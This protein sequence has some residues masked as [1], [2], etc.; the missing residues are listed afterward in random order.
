[1][2]ALLCPV[3]C[4]HYYLDKTKKIRKDISTLFISCNTIGPIK[5]VHPNTISGWIKRVI[6]DAYE[7]DKKSNG[8]LLSRA[9][10]EIR[11]QGT[12]YALYANTAVEDIM[13]QCRW[14]HANTFT[15]FYLRDVTKQMS[16][17][18]TLPPLI[19]SGTVLNEK[20]AT[21]P[22]RVKKTQSTK[23]RT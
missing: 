16:G 9:T 5:G 20:N 23:S 10:H 18:H 14:A 1:M 13:K 6:A 15:T 22:R 8:P 7:M 3:R 21:K 19:V 2:D 12:S 4:M 11:A 17:I